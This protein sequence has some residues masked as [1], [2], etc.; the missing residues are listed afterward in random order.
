M[1]QGDTAYVDFTLAEL[2]GMVPDGGSPGQSRTRNNDLT[3]ATASGASATISAMCED[4]YR[5]QV[6]T[7]TDTIHYCDTITVPAYTTHIEYRDKIVNE[8]SHAQSFFFW[9]GIIAL[10][11][12]ALTIILRVVIRFVKV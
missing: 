3:V 6:R 11:L 4:K 9:N 7:R 1:L 10:A 2:S 8:M 5:L 12:V